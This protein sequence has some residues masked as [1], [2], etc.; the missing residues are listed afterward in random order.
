MLVSLLISLGRTWFLKLNAHLD[1]LPDL[2][3]TP[4]VSAMQRMTAS[5]APPLPSSLLLSAPIF[6]TGP[7]TESSDVQ[8]Y[9]MRAAILEKLETVFSVFL[10]CH[11]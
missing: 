11:F 5:G 6:V 1:P 3:F 2:S 8:P 9:P 7:A 4:A 10:V